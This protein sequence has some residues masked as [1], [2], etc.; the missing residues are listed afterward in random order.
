LE[1]EL[2]QNAWLVVDPDPSLIFEGKAE[3]KWAMGMDKL[4][5][6]PAMLSGDIGSA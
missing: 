4:G 6:D 3:D 1:Q 5:L 2:Q